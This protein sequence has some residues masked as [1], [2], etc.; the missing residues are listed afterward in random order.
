MKTSKRETFASGGRALAPVNFDGVLGLATD[1]DGTLAREGRVDAD[2]IAGLAR[3]RASGRRLFLVTGRVMPDLKAVF[4]RLDLFDLVVAENGGLIYAPQSGK[5]RLLA[6]P[7]PEALLDALRQNGVS[8][9]FVGESIVAT[10]E[11]HRAAASDAIRD[12]GLNMRIILNKEAVMILPAEVDKASGFVAAL[13]DLDLPACG[14]AAVGD[15][16]N[17]VALFRASGVA[18]AV[19]NA[20][21]AVKREAAFVTRDACGAGVVELMEAILATDAADGPARDSSTG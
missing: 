3:F 15:A 10:L 21:P 13:A 1:Y 20:L 18:V 2:T 4:P 14:F 12:L 9:L 6:P 19:A 16:E 5:T 11:P 7:P 8:P 17:D